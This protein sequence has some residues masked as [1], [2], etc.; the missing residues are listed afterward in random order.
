[1]I[2]SAGPRR[3]HKKAPALPGEGTVFAAG[4]GSAGQPG[5]APSGF[6]LAG[7]AGRGKLFLIFY[8]NP[9]GCRCPNMRRGTPPACIFGRCSSCGALNMRRIRDDACIFRPLRQTQLPASST[10]RGRRRCPCSASPVS[11][12]GSGSATQPTTAPCFVHRTRSLC[13]PQWGSGHRLRFLSLRGRS[14]CARASRCERQRQRAAARG[15]LLLCP[16]ADVVA[17]TLP[18]SR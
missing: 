3:G 5:A 13:L 10:G 1:M 14:C 9:P 17:V 8:L 4:S 18:P 6:G 2:P 15:E 7:A 11:A 16:T 12:A